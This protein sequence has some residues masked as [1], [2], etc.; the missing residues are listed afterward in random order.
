M[1]GSDGLANFHCFSL[2][3]GKMENCYGLGLLLTLGT[4]KR[5]EMLQIFKS[6]SPQ[7]SLLDDLNFY[8]NSEK[9]LKAR[10][11]DKTSFQE[12]HFRP[13]R[14]FMLNETSLLKQ[15]QGVGLTKDY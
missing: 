12:E 1:G 8:D 14:L 4:L 9:L 6:Y 2:A 7:T 15:Q 10:R 3:S 5:L 13:Y 11:T